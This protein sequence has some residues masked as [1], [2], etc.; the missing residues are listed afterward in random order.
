MSPTESNMTLQPVILLLM[1]LSVVASTPCPYKA[2]SCDD[3]KNPDR[4]DCNS[5]NLTSLPTLESGHF[6][7]TW[8]DIRNNNITEI[9]KGY[10]FPPQLTRLDINYNHLHDID[11]GTLASLPLTV[12]DLSDNY[13]QS[14][15]HILFPPSL[16]TLSLYNNNIT[17]VCAQHFSKSITVLDLSYNPISNI[18]TDTF[19]HL[20]NLTEIY[21][22]STHLTSIDQLSLPESLTTVDMSNARLIHIPLSLTALTNLETLYLLSNQ[23]LQCSCKAPALASWYRARKQR[24]YI[25]IDGDCIN[26][27]G[28]SIDYFLDNFE[29]LCSSD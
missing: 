29:K 10:K 1:I 27:G 17:T 14:I 18:S 28:S 15:S 11:P 22:A 2:C 24:G 9:P 12:L 8:L 26:Q 21:L 3:K 7:Q 23:D 13:L 20:T 19:S 4:I 5:K 25:D 6:T 16:T